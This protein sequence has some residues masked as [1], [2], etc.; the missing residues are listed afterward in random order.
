MPI[1]MITLAQAAGPQRMGR[2]MSVVGVPM[3]LAPVLGPVLGGAD[4]HEPELALDLLRQP[5]DRDR[6]PGAGRAAAAGRALDRA[7]RRGRA[8]E[9][10]LARAAA[11]LAGRRAR[12]SSGSARSSTHGSVT[13]VARWLPIVVGLA[14][15]AAFVVRARGA[16]SSRS[17]TCGCSAARGFAAAAR[18]GVPRRRGA[19]RRDAPAA[20]LLPGGARRVAA[21][22]G[23]LHGAAGPRRG[24]RDEL[25]R[26]ADGPHRRRARRDRRAA[27]ADG[28]RRSPFTHGRA[29]HVVLAARR[30][31]SSCAASAWAS[32]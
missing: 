28:R 19:V 1:G 18:D 8:V 2:V 20:A 10:R 24:A 4:R 11:A 32:R 9:A 16:S 3:L 31:R 5:A 23:L 15:V 7:R 17:S 30:S 13:G 6:R 29:G 25:R 21:D 26:A 22:A 14:L 12:S 27:H